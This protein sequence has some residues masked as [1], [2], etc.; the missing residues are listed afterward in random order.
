M[1]SE[2]N[3]RIS[4]KLVVS[5]YLNRTY[6]GKEAREF[7]TKQSNYQM[8]RQIQHSTNK[9]IVASAPNHTWA[10]DLLDLSSYSNH[11]HQ[12]RYVF[13][14]VD[15]FSRKV[16]IEKLTQKASENTRDALKRICDRAGIIPTVIM[17]DNGTE[18]KG[19]FAQFCSNHQQYVTERRQNYDCCPS[20]SRAGGASAGLGRAR[21]LVKVKSL[22]LPGRGALFRDW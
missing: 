6:R 14:C 7:L 4:Y 16:W 13:V 21:G 15:V 10:V 18:F 17:S 2:R 12:N 11:N 8:T 1:R 22:M 5:K 3:N 9:P 20:G 19:L